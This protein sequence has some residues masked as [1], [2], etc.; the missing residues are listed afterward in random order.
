MVRLSWSVIVGLAG[1]AMAEL[2]DAKRDAIINHAHK[3]SKVLQRKDRQQLQLVVGDSA[4]D[5]V[6]T[7]VEAVEEIDGASYVWKVGSWSEC[8]ADCGPG[9]RQRT[10][11]CTNEETGNVIDDSA[12]MDD[13]SVAEPTKPSTDEECQ[14]RC[15]RCDDRN[16]LFRSIGLAEPPA[17]PVRATSARVCQVTDPKFS[18]CDRRVENSM[19]TQVIAIHSGFK[20]VPDAASEQKQYVVDYVQNAT[21]EFEERLQD[22]KSQL[23]SVESVLAQPANLKADRKIQRALT[24]VR[25]VLKQRV[26]D[27]ETAIMN[28]TEIVAMIHAQLDVLIDDTSMQLSSSVTPETTATPTTTVKRVKASL[29]TCVDATVNLFASLGCAACNPS[30]VSETVE[31]HSG[32]FN[33]VNVSSNLCTSVY[34]DC[35]ST[36][37]DSRKHLRNALQTMRSLQSRLAKTAAAL[38]PALLA[39][40]SSIAFDWLPG[41]A[42][43]LSA[44]A[45]YAGVDTYMPDLTSLDCIKRASAY[46]LPPATKVEDFCD[47]FFNSWN[48]Q[49]T[50]AN[51]VKDVETGVKAMD[52]LR[53]CDRC[54]HVIMSKMTETMSSGKGGLDVTIGLLPQ[55]LTEAGCAGLS[56]TPA[57]NAA[58]SIKEKLVSG[59]LNLFAIK[60]G[61]LYSGGERAALAVKSKRAMALILAR[62]EISTSDKLAQGINAPATYIHTINYENAGLDPV[63]YAN[64][65]W[66]VIDGATV[67]PP[68]S[69]WDLRGSDEVGVI[70]TDMN[71]T[72]HASCNP[73]SGDAPYWFCANAKVCNGTIP[74]DANEKALL[75]AHPRCVKGLCVDSQDAVDGKCPEIAM[76]P[77]TKKGQFDHSYFSKY[78]YVGPVPPPSSDLVDKEGAATA[79]A[80]TQALVYASGVCDPAF[81]KKVDEKGLPTLVVGDTCKYAQCLAYA[82]ANEAQ[83]ACQSGLTKACANLKQSCPSVVCD[84]TLSLWNAPALEINAE[85]DSFAQASDTVVSGSAAQAAWWTVIGFFLV[86]AVM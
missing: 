55:A 45:R 18:C 14:G 21:A 20:A 31:S 53:R 15:I 50:I 38:Q 42:H 76:C 34:K 56:A 39:L 61:D 43:P 3:R 41:S 17:L 58:D 78:K 63:T 81:M 84:R 83:P 86:V 59:K 25:D 75:V 8:S 80:I 66:D 30:F 4:T 64:V 65:S 74:C 33:S 23:S 19:V 70:A 46:V 10:V 2:K 9:L 68:P 35:A 11:E 16:D 22:T 69:V 67:N 37:R 54:V 62:G 47:N 60:E 36:V 71:C 85:G 7:D 57:T 48:Y 44:D 24:T 26:T 13:Q 5:P 52:V 32:F 6:S 51:L 1:S 79:S 40:W 73:E 77:T 27:L 12:C 29:A 28:S 82:L 72:S 49:F